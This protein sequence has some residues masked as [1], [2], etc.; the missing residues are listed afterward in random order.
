M[1]ECFVSEIFC[2]GTNITQKL[3]GTN[4]QRVIVQV[5]NE[6]RMIEKKMSFFLQNSEVSQINLLAG[7]SYSIISESVFKVIKSAK[8]LSEIT[9]GY[10][11]ITS[12]PLIKLWGVF[13]KDEKVPSTSEIREALNLIT[14]KDILL[15]E[16]KHAVKLLKKGQKIDLGAIAKGF[17]ADRAIEIYQKNGI[18][19]AMVNLGGNVKVLG[20]KPDSN[21]WVVG[22]QDPERKR[23][24]LIGGIKVT[25]KTVVT[26]G[27]YVRY[28][29]NNN[30]KF[31]HIF[32][33]KTGYPSDSDLV[34]V[35]IVMDKSIDADALSTA[36]F[37][38]GTNKGMELLSTI[39]N[40]DGIFVTKDKQI[41]VTDGLREKLTLLENN[42]I[43]KLI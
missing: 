23:G 32:D 15:N 20:S 25:D 22:I 35:T 6:M 40:A 3:Y 18:K 21:P 12:A 43:Y 24:N 4:C 33:L 14:Y 2:M 28:F 31:H 13:T 5:E 42:T 30:N 1:E 36:I 27:G 34:S 7:Q 16:K 41:M 29:E 8:Y 38:M 37:V 26:S 10:F 39:E 11:D 9:N 17:A 19:S